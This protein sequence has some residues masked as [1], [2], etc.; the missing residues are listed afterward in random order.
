MDDP[1]FYGFPV[2]GEAGPKVGQ[3]AGG[4]ET[5]ATTRTFERDE[6]AFARVTRFLQRHLPSALGPVIYSRTCLYTLTPDRDFV[7]DT[8]P[9]RPEVS[10][11]IGAGHGFK[12]ASVVGRIVAELAVD[13]RSAHDLEPFALDRA[14]LQLADPPRT[15]MV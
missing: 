6:A 3:D 4:E 10:V 5:T 2:F 7:L 13:G 8:L 9:E 1:C 14:I 12:F 15:Y 11:A